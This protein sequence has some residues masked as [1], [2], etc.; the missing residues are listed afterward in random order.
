M[1]P[2]IP[3]SLEHIAF[4]LLLSCFMSFIISGV[5]TFLAIGLVP[6]FLGAWVSSWVSSWAIAFPAVLL[7]A[8]FVRRVLH[9]LVIAE[10]S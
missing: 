1:R 2:F 4:G 9:R 7:V 5:S 8:P 3:R 10:T 6:H